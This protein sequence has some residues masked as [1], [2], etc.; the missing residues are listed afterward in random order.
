MG[1]REPL[2]IDLI[3]PENPTHQFPRHPEDQLDD[4][5]PSNLSFA[6]IASSPVAERRQSTGYLLG[7]KLDAMS[8]QQ[9]RRVPVAAQKS[10]RCQGQLDNKIQSL[11]TPQDA[12][13]DIRQTQHAVD[14]ASYLSSAQALQDLRDGWIPREGQDLEDTHDQEMQ[15]VPKESTTTKRPYTE[16]SSAIG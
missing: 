4:K 16:R 10:G 11:N 8:T 13:M 7:R 3:S 15:D 2:I 12:E 6:D 9:K 5:S 1:S 14:I